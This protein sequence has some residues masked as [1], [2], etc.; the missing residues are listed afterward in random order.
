L[1]FHTAAVFDNCAAV[2]KPG[3]VAG[4]VPA[5]NTSS[6]HTSPAVL[7]VAAVK[8]CTSAAEPV[9]SAV[10]GTLTYFQVA[11]SVAF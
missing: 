10:H 11:L 7:P 4:E 3:F 9:A 5:K 2:P 8:N 6:I 1:A